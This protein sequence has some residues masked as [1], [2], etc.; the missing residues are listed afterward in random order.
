[1]DAS[2]ESSRPT[3][4]DR[5]RELLASPLSSRITITSV[6][7][8]FA[9]PFVL[10]LEPASRLDLAGRDAWAG[11]VVFP[12]VA[13]RMDLCR[14]TGLDGVEP[15]D[16][17]GHTNGSGF[18]LTAADREWFNRELARLAQE[19]N[20]AVALKND[21]DQ[22]SLLEAAF[23]F[24]VNEQC[25]QYSEC[26]QLLPLAA[27]AIDVFALH[28][29]LAGDASRVATIWLIFM[30][31]QLATTAYALHLDGESLRPLWSQPLQ[32]VFYRQ[33]I[34]LVVIQSIV[35]AVAGARLPWHKLRRSGDVVVP[36]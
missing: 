30:G 8:T 7:P 12:F 29:L 34:Y 16:V 20:L 13:A 23:D 5:N 2:S 28:G 14:A 35:S 18:D 9:Q 25:F 4:S 21:L 36:A 26:D 15:D 11:D 33:L 27:P 10:R 22:V 1:M 31:I 19:R 6:G 32:Q 17:D 24:A 3:D